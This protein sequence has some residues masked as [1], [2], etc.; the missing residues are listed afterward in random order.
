MVKNCCRAW[1][2][3]NWDYAGTNGKKGKA[4][5]GFDTQFF[6]EFVPVAFHF[7]CR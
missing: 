1:D 3:F 4:D 2:F 7:L 5:L 6:M